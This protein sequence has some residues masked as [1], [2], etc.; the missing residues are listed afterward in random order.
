MRSCRRWLTFVAA[1]TFLLVAYTVAHGEAKRADA[2][3]TRSN[4]LGPQPNL[5]VR[6]LPTRWNG[7]PM[8]ELSNESHF[9]LSHVAIYSWTELLPVLWEGTTAPKLSS[10][11][12][13]PAAIPPYN[14][15]PGEKL[16]FVG[17]SEGPEEFSLEWLSAGGVE[18]Y[19]NIVLSH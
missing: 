14:L 1:G 4:A 12:G 10:P 5:Y 17:P 2:T 15:T 7:D 11:F 18:Q 13:S 3:I 16:C 6:E 9:T 8:Y 19:E